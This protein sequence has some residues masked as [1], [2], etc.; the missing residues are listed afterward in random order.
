MAGKQF[1]I[2]KNL[3]EML[4]YCDGVLSSNKFYVIILYNS[5]DDIPSQIFFLKIHTYYISYTIK[6]IYKV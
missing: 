6:I 1:H 2:T 3:V 4:C 5:K